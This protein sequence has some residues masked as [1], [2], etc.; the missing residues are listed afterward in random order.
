M[1]LPAR[2]SRS[3]GVLERTALDAP[4]RAPSRRGREARRLRRLGDAGLLRGPAPIRHE[5][6]AV[7]ERVRLFDVSHMG[8]IETT[9][10]QALELLQ[11][12]LSND[13][14]KI[15]AGRRAVQRAVPRGRRRARRPV[16]LPP[17]ARPLPDG[18]ECR[19]P[20][21]GPAPGFAPTRRGS[22]VAVVDRHR[23]LRDARRPG[24]ARRASS[25][26]RSPTR[27]CR[28]AC[29]R[30]RA[31]S[32][33]MRCSSAGPATPAR[34]ASSCSARPSSPGAVGRA[35]RRGAVPAGLGARDTLRLEACFHLYGNE[36]M[37]ERGPIE[38]GLGWCCKEE[39]GFIG[40]RRGRGRARGGPG[41]EAR[42]L[43][44]RGRRGSRARATR[45]SAA[46]W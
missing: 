12:L 30:R 25:C 39:T 10:P 2:S 36:L 45:W 28:R 22:D 40:A 13:V 42:R 46:G 24:P 38:A 18:H 3:D 26:R 44:D 9:G 33:A 19:Q 34:T 16:H 32:P 29:S 8:E 15:A 43:R 23:G 21:A 1:S 7:R 37:P 27:R 4:A 11:H 41:R 20:R 17:R 35:V 14:A 6:M 31:R 5:H